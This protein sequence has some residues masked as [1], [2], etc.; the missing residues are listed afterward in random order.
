MAITFIIMEFRELVYRGITQISRIIDPFFWTYCWLHLNTF[1][2]GLDEV[3]LVALILSAWARPDAPT[4]P[5][6]QYIHSSTQ[7]VTS[8]RGNY[9]LKC[10]GR[11]CSIVTSRFWQLLMA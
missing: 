1:L 2:P 11:G 6:Q 5:E 9:S 10:R 3:V 7:D 8:A 4:L